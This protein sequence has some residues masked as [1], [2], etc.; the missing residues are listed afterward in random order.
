[1]QRVVSNRFLAI[2]PG[3]REMGIAVLEGTKL[4]YHGVLVIRR[5]KSPRETL[6]RACKSVAR[7]IEDFRPQ[8]LAIEKTFVRRNRHTALLNVVADEIV[9]LAK[10][11]RLQVIGLSPSAVKKGICGDGWA[12]KEEVAKAVLTRFPELKAYLVHERK[13]KERFHA[14]MFDAVALGV[15][16]QQ[17]QNGFPKQVSARLRFQAE[18]SSLERAGSGR[19]HHQ[20]L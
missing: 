8:V 4:V 14:N 7:L 17:H 12:S 5:G 9:V 19:Q 13:W 11:S 6:E 15:V 2:D 10:Q 16:A 1:M 20:L 3:T 18:E